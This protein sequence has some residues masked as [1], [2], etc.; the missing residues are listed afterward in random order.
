M[1]VH[2]H[3]TRATQAAGVALNAD[4]C[5]VKKQAGLTVDTGSGPSLR[6]RN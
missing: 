3:D 5:S 2:R 6:E 1:A 4:D